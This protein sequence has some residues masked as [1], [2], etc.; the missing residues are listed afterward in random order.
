MSSFEK[1]FGYVQQGLGNRQLQEEGRQRRAWGSDIP[2]RA[3][4]FQEHLREEGL[5][6]LA[7]VKSMPYSCLCMSAPKMSAKVRKENQR[8]DQIA[9]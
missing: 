6:L 1:C 5:L 8:E 4:P 7:S 3:H 2:F 9:S